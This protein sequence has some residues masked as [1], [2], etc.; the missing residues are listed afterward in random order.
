MAPRLFAPLS[1]IL[2]EIEEEIARI[3]RDD[4]LQGSLQQGV[5]VQRAVRNPGSSS[6]NALSTVGAC[7]S[8]PSSERPGNCLELRSARSSNVRPTSVSCTGGQRVG[9]R[10]RRLTISSGM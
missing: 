2:S 7:W 6:A 10:R 5:V 4:Q 9:A 8:P 3:R 1:R